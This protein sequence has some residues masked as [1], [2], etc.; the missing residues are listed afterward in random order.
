MPLFYWVMGV[1]IV[2]TL[3]PA[4]LY[5]VLYVVTGEPACD[6]RARAFWAAARVFALLGF[7]ILVWGHVFQGLWQLGFG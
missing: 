7:N 6:R 3:V 1:L 4:A 5:R 2:G